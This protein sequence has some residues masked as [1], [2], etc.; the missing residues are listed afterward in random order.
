MGA[1]LAAAPWG[2]QVARVEAL[3]AAVRD[4]L[5]SLRSMSA[6]LEREVETVLD[7]HGGAGSARDAGE[8]DALRTEN[9]QLKEALEGRA[10]IERAKGMV[11]VSYGFDEETAFHLLVSIARSERRKVRQIASDVVRRVPVEHRAPPGDT[12]AVVTALRRDGRRETAL[13]A[14]ERERKGTAG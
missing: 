4:T 8:L 13:R 14:A 11:M 5:S 3:L 6:Q 2:D 1:D 12:E 7:R 10:L 9:A